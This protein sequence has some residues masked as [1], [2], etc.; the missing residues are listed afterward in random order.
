MLTACRASP[1]SVNPVRNPQLK[2]QRSLLIP[3]RLPS[4]RGRLGVALKGILQ[5]FP[6]QERLFLT[7]T[8]E[9]F[10]VLKDVSLMRQQ[11]NLNAA[12]SLTHTHK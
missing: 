4:V 8:E 1:Q 6:S 2:T 9:M 3:V 11:I 7:V 12:L 5:Q 10:M